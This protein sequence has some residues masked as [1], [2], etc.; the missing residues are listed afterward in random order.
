VSF[1]A[2]TLCV[3]SQRVFI[4]VVYFVIDSVRELLDTPS[5]LLFMNL[6]DAP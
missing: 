3:A 1:A 2:I 5:Y 4:A 6:G